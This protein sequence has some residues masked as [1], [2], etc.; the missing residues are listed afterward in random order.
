M[1]REEENRLKDLFNFSYNDYYVNCGYTNEMK[2]WSSHVVIAKYSRKMFSGFKPMAS[3]LALQCSTN[4]AMKTH[5]VGA[6]QFGEFIV[7]MRGTRHECYVNCGHTNEMKMWSSQLYLRFKQSHSM[8]EKC[9]RGF[10]GIRT[11]DLCVSVAVLHQLSYEDPNVRNRP[12][13]GIHRTRERNET[14]I[15]CEMR[16]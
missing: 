3:A 4:W 11:L 10:N 13:C 2:M 5:T 7:P 9:F 1:K 8:P 15:L 16:T 14:W 6:G 12:I